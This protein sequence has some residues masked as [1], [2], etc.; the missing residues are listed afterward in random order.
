MAFGQA[1][2]LSWDRM[3]ANDYK[4]SET[5]LIL[6]YNLFIGKS[7]VGGFCVLTIKIGEKKLGEIEMD[8]DAEGPAVK[9]SAENSFV[10]LLSS[11]IKEVSNNPS[12]SWEGKAI[13]NDF[14]ILFPKVTN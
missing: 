11:L 4:L 7:F 13:I 1:P 8:I 6:D 2:I 9:S 10:L 12:L 14:G 3:G 5:G